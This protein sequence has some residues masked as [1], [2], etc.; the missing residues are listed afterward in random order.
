MP[1]EI[2]GQLE[3]TIEV[4]TAFDIR[5]KEVMCHCLYWKADRLTLVSSCLQITN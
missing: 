2:E 3:H 5:G 1:I 4:H